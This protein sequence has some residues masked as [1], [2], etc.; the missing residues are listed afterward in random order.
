MSEQVY[1]NNE[2][3]VGGFTIHVVAASV[4]PTYLLSATAYSSL[5]LPEGLAEVAKEFDLLFTQRSCCVHNFQL[6]GSNNENDENDGLDG[7]MEEW[8][9]S[10]RRPL[11]D[12]SSSS[13]PL[14]VFVEGAAGVHASAN[15]EYTRTLESKGK[16][17]DKDEDKDPIYTK[18]SSGKWMLV[19]CRAQMMWQLKKRQGLR[20]RDTYLQVAFGRANNNNNNNSSKVNK[21]SSLPSS[22]TAHEGH[23]GV[24]NPHH[25]PASVPLELLC[26]KEYHLS[27]KSWINSSIRL[28]T[29]TAT[30][31]STA[32]TT[33]TSSSSP[34][35]H[36]EASRAHHTNHQPRRAIEPPSL[37][38]VAAWVLSDRIPVPSEKNR[39]RYQ[40]TRSIPTHTL[41]TQYQHTLYSTQ[42]SILTHPSNLNNHTP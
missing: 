8:Y 20:D 10:T 37:S 40:H 13:S 39:S 41:S 21:E 29:R 27:N 3:T 12:P 42:Y 38:T 11:H 18:K 15:G 28:T 1:G 25:R 24:D 6:D 7:Q 34:R 4:W 14:N 5:L 22:M 2:G 23:D 32:T 26:W 19:F 35:F 16:G 17:R 30:S 36:E 9:G 31:S 33:T